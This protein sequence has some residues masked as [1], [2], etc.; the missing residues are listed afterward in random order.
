MKVVKT[1]HQQ[2][3]TNCGKFIP[4]GEKSIQYVAK[5]ENKDKSAVSRFLCL[6][7]SMAKISEMTEE[8]TGVFHGKEI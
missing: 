5:L 2:F 3:C 1:N 8:L 4:R 6:D 7:C